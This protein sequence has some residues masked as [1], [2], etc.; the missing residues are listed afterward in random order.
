M[1]EGI[2]GSICTFIEGRVTNATAKVALEVCASVANALDPEL[3]S[4][5]TKKGINA[6][7]LGTVVTG[8]LSL[9]DEAIPVKAAAAPAAA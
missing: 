5:L 8:I 7:T 4:V 2:L 1:N 3:A 6:T 9:V